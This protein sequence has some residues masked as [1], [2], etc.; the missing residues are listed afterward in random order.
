MI[1]DKNDRFNSGMSLGQ[2]TG[3][4]VSG[5]AADNLGFDRAC[6]LL[7][8]FLMFLGVCY[9]PMLFI[10]IGHRKDEKLKGILGDSLIKNDLKNENSSVV[11]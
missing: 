9:V 2:L 6:G 7:G 11:T 5:F 3:P 8:L 4:I 1:S 10:H